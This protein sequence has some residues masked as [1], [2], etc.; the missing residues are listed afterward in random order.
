MAMW[1]FWFCPMRSQSEIRAPRYDDSEAVV[2]SLPPI[3]N[4]EWKFLCLFGRLSL[5]SLSVF[6]RLQFEEPNLHVNLPA[7]CHRHDYDLMRS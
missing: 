1:A 3:H 6:V 5:D 7:R 2:L 4:R